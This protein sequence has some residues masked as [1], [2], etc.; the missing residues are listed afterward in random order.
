MTLALYQIDSSFEAT[1]LALSEG[2]DPRRLQFLHFIV[3]RVVREDRFNAVAAARE[4]AAYLD[5]DPHDIDRHFTRPNRPDAET[6]CA[7]VAEFSLGWQTRVM[8]HAQAAALAAAWVAEFDE[9]TTFFSN[10]SS[11]ASPIHLGRGYDTG[12]LFDEDLEA[13]VL[14]VSPTKAGLFWSAEDA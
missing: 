4:F 11:L 6:I 3:Y 8:P 2:I 10:L 13:C 14:A 1:K 9:N 5:L 12:G 7:N